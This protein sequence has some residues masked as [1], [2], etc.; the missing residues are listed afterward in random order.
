VVERLPSKRKA[1][2]SVPSSEKKKKRE[3]SE[4]GSHIISTWLHVVPAGPTAFAWRAVIWSQ[5][6]RVWSLE[7]GIARQRSRKA[8]AS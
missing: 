5:P 6:G 8:W 1:L 7:A 3:S 4:R 2:G